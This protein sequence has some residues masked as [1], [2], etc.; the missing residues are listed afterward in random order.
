[1]K[2]REKREG[3]REGRRGGEGRGELWLCLNDWRE[4]YAGQSDRMPANEIAR[5]WLLSFLWL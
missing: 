4:F 5:M 2:G 1:M 3:G